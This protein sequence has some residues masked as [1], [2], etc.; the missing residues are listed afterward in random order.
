MFLFSRSKHIHVAR[1]THFLA[2]VSASSQDGCN[3][4]VA[5][6]FI[7]DGAFASRL[8]K[9]RRQSCSKVR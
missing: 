8:D 4:D 7:I 1:F 6:D 3:V 2:Q 9:F 5:L